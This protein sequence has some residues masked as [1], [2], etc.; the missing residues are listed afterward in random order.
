MA[1]SANFTKVLKVIISA[2]SLFSIILFTNC[3]SSKDSNTS[4]FQSF[5]EVETTNEK[6][7]AEILQKLSGV[8]V[9]GTGN[10]TT[11]RVN[12]GSFHTSPIAEP[13]FLL[14]GVNYA[15]NFQ[16]VQNSINPND[17]ESAQV[18]KTPGELGRFGLR[19]ANG[20]IDIKLKQ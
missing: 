16:S 1:T 4:E 14:N 5:R 3:S 11:V 15:T 10:N 6:T 19:G 17:V 9:Q 12:V 8:T 13:L 20:V 7:M 18:Y 2:V